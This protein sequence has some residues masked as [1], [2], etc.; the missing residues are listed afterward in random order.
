MMYGK[1]EDAKAKFESEKKAIKDYIAD[2]DKYSVCDDEDD[3][4]AVYREDS[5]ECYETMI[6][7]RTIE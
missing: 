6:V 5:C 2:S 1:F 4:F 7:S 3:Y